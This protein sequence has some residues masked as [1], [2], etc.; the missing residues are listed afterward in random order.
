MIGIVAALRQELS[1]LIRHVRNPVPKKAGGL[2]MVTGRLNDVE[3]AIASTGIGKVRAAAAT[4]ALI[5]AFAPG[6]VWCIGLGGALD[7]K[8][9]AGD[10]IIADEL[11][12]HDLDL[13]GGSRVAAL[14]TKGRG[15]SLVKCDKRLVA[16]AKGDCHHYGAQTPHRG[17]QLVDGDCH[18]S[19]RK[20]LTPNQIYVGRIVTGDRAVLKTKDRKEL[21]RRTRALCVEMEGAAVGYTCARNRIPFIVIR[22]V[23]DTAGGSALLQFAKNAKRVAQIPQ[24]IALSMLHRRGTENAEENEGRNDG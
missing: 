15:A 19:H 4:Q 3:V 1:L 12:Q 14:L 22:A 2:D 13:S 16:L 21:A 17:G 23:S 7:E 20:R 5:D 6:E 8:L 18:L 11:Y 10:V 9:K 24:Q